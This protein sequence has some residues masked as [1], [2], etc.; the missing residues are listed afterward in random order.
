MGAG[1]L[2]FGSDSSFFPR[3]WQDPIRREQRQLLKGLALTPGE[4]GAIFRENFERIFPV[5]GTARKS[6]R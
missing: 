5:P 3:G 4:E 1:R 2:L 6:G